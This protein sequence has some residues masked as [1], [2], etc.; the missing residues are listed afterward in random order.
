MKST[1]F[2]FTS[3]ENPKEIK[4]ASNYLD[5]LTWDGS[6]WTAEFK[7][8]KFYHYPREG[9]D[10]GHT[11]SIL[12]YISDAGKKWQLKFEGTTFVHSPEGNA[13][14]SHT[15]DHICYIGWDGR[16]WRGELLILINHLHD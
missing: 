9:K 2:V 10:K 12:N 3:L 13:S 16:K 14:K 11:D 6:L 7:D 4:T 8:G 15:D 5:Y 1:W